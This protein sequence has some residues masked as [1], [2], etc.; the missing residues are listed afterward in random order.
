MLRLLQLELQK[1]LLNKTSK[2]LIFISFIL[3]FFVIL[4]SSLK[5]NVFG[6]FT[7]E[8]GELGVFNFPI[9][10]HLTTFFS[11]QFKFFFAIVVVSM[12]GNEYSNK[13]LKQNLID[14][15]SKKE[16]IL[17]KF[18]T[19][20]FFSFVSTILIGLISLCI[21]LYYSSYNEFGIIIQEINFLLAYFVKLVGFFSLCLFLGMLVKRSAFAL[22]FLFVLYIV[23]WIVFWGSYEILG[24]TESAFKVKRFMPL[25]SMYKLIDQPFQRVAMTKFPEKA[26]LVYDYAVHWHEIVIVLGWT[27]LFIFLSYSLLKKRDL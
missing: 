11:S 3:P 16:F 14:G 8:L 4:L 1:L 9:I 15:L 25:E 7:L 2:V 12:I 21:G 10:W 18:Y 13:T 20:V 26:E 19:I 6:F 22:A 17:S 24:N 23:E 27:A 5:I